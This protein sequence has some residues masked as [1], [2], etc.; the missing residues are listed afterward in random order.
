MAMYESRGFCPNN[1]FLHYGAENEVSANWERT[2]EI[3]GDRC[4]YMVYDDN[5]CVYN[6]ECYIVDALVGAKGT[7]GIEIA[8]AL[9]YLVPVCIYAEKGRPICCFD[10]NNPYKIPANIGER[11]GKWILSSEEDPAKTLLLEDERFLV[12]IQDTEKEVNVYLF[13]K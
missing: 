7:L 9:R 12:A 5:N 13:K 10:L 4:G 6:A 1:S 8:C 3:L 2:R 11:E